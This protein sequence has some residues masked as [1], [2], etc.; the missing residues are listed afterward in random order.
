MTKND[1]AKTA[2]TVASVRCNRCIIRY[3]M[4]QYDL[5]YWKYRHVTIPK[6]N[7]ANISFFIY[8]G[9]QSYQTATTLTTCI[10]ILPLDCLGCT[11]IILAAQW[12]QQ[13][14]TSCLLGETLDSNQP[15]FRGPY[16]VHAGQIT[17]SIRPFT[18]FLHP[19]PDQNGPEWG[20]V[21]PWLGGSWQ[22][23]LFDVLASCFLFLA[24][25]RWRDHDPSVY[26]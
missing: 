4:V 11:S 5:V 8:C 9:H 18:A 3:R 25:V 20:S 17:D 2:S 12:I 19:G 14:I 23:G 15:C 6:T 10:Y 13:P 1:S 16:F 24:R 22:V 26:Y 7:Q 21:A